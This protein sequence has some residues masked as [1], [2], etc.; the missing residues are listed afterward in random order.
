MPSGAVARVPTECDGSMHTGMR[1]S[2]LTTGT[3]EKSTKLRCGSPMLVFMPR[4]PNTTLRLPSDAR[5]SA[6]FSDSSRVMPKPRLIS[7]GNSCCLPTSFNSSK[8]CVLRVPICSRT[9]VGLP[10]D[11]RA[12]RISSTCDSCVTSIAITR[13]PCLPASSKTYGRHLAPKPWNAY[14]LVR[15][16]YAPIRGQPW[17]GGSS[18]AHPCPHLLVLLHPLHHRA[19]R[20]RRVDGAQAGEY[21]QAVLA[22]AHAV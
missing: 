3:C 19:G 9:P 18:H 22:E 12:A 8:F 7:T 10:V 13:M 11:L 15:G 5:Y 21:V 14:G 6:A 2:R 4:K 16:L 1:V 17:R 20:L